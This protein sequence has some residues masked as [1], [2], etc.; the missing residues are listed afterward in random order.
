M[1]NPLNCTEAF[2]MIVRY[3]VTA[4]AVFGNIA[5]EIADFKFWEFNNELFA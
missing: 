5:T 4:N 3:L 1:G 2:C